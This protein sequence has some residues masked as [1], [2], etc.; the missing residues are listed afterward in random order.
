[1]LLLSII[2]VIINI[3]FTY[4]WLD[5]AILIIISSILLKSKKYLFVLSSKFPYLTIDDYQEVDI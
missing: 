5:G 2:L 3:Y 1:M 4:N